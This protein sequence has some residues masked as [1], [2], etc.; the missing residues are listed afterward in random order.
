MATSPNYMTVQNIA[1]DTAALW[2]ITVPEAIDGIHAILDDEGYERTCAL[3][4]DEW[5]ELILNARV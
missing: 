2:Q 3:T 5:V 1:D 4:E